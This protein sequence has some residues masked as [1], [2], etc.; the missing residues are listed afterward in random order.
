MI[1][2]QILRNIIFSGLFLIPFIPFLVSS[3][4]F[5]PFI[6]TKAFAFRIIVEIIFGAWIILAYTDPAYRPR[7]SLIAYCLA[8]FLIIIG[9]AN[10]FGEAPLKSFWSN[11]ERMEG[12][13]ALLHLGA[14]FLVASSIF[15]TSESLSKRASGG[16]SWKH[17]WNTSLVASLL[18]AI[19]SLFQLAGVFKINQGGVRVDG[20]L[21]N[22]AYLAVYMLIHIF[23]A[24]IFFYKN[25]SNTLLKW[26]YGVLFILLTIILYHTATRGAILGFLGGFIIVA[27]LNL[28]KRAEPRLRKGS[29]VALVVLALLAGGFWLARDSSLVGASPVLSRFANITTEELKG[30]GRSFVWPMALKGVME[31]PLLGWG[32]D[33][34]NYIFN[35]Y[36]DPNMFRLEPWFD[37]AHNIFLDWAVAGGLLGLLS[38]LSLYGALLFLIWR[39]ID[40]I[41]YT[42]RTLLTGLISAYFFHNF[43]VFDHLISY[44]LF[45][46]LLA[47]IHSESVREQVSESVSAPRESGILLPVVTLATIGVIFVVNIGPA[48][49]NL[50]LLGALAGSYDLRG[51]KT[52]SIILFKK[53]YAG[54]HLGRSEVVEQIASRSVTILSSDLPIEMR[55]DFYSFV[56]DAVSAHAEKYSS[57]A[58]YQLLAGSLYSSFGKLDEALSFLDKAIELSPGKQSI[59]LEKGSVLINQGERREALNVFKEAY[60][61]APEN[62]DA[63]VAYLI[64]AIYVG[65]RELERSLLRELPE[66]ILRTDRRLLSAY[67]VNKRI[68]ETSRML[69]AMSEDDPSLRAQADEF[70]R[71]LEAG[72]I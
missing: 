34:F 19:Y 16:V 45:F 15:K 43:F 9:L 49:T 23:V 69:D 57:D 62:I 40:N 13:I 68:L 48:R 26:V 30:G 61:M 56:S 50:N 38:Y 18:M 60:E 54:T 36:Y 17:W 35:K 6:V 72:G 41:S 59:R 2:K 64:G 29:A 24:G 11:F 55:N 53:A 12:Y 51:G 3:S 1:N 21:G 10:L 28:S 22:A 37:R 33:N 67:A 27:L 70:L 66:Q 32:Q 63:L 47:Q 42:E 58:R 39:R 7:K 8:G 4:F 52:E 46:A 65:D 25:R 14:F 44:I 5:F 20:T 71:Q 31:K